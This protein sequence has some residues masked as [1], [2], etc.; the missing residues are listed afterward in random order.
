MNVKT[1]DTTINVENSSGK[2]SKGKN[3]GPNTKQKST[4]MNQDY[5]ALTKDLI[6]YNHYPG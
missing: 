1:N 5:E 4:I 2:L 3:H 6:S